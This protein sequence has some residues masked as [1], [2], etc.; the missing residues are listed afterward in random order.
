MIGEDES[1]TFEN[2]APV[3]AITATYIV[4][5]TGVNAVFDADTT[6]FDVYGINGLKILKAADNKAVDSLPAGLYII[7]GKKV[8]KR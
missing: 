4:A 7:N 1:V 5:S 8:I 2:V 6:E 3:Q